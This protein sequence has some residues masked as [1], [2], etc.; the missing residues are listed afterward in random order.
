MSGAATAS[1]PLF[2]LGTPLFPGMVLP[3]H[4]FE[5]RYR[6]LVADLVAASAA[7]EQPEFGVVSIRQGHEVGADAATA[8]AAVGCSAVLRR[9]LELPDG[10]FEVVAVGGRRFRLGPTA[11]GAHGYL[12]ADVDW[13]A[14]APGDEQQEA[15]LAAQ[16]RREFLAYRARLAD[17]VDPADDGPELP[18]ALA[19]FV[20]LGMLLSNG[21]RQ[22]VLDLPGTI[23]RLQLLL[24]LIARE[25]AVIDAIG[26]VPATDVLRIAPSPN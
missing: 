14:E 9:V 21:D 13:L 16:L 22:R 24:D 18:A 17:A 25:D 10:R 3:L 5:P 8:L 20:A 12:L 2:P 6:A 11:V 23:Q 1:I 26:A 15:A 4:I 7:G 19:Y